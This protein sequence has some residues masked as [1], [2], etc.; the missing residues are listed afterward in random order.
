[1]VLEAMLC[2]LGYTPTMACNGREAL[3][4]IE[5]RSFDLVLTDMRMPDLDGAAMTQAI[6]R[7]LGD[8]APFVIAVTATAESEAAQTTDGFD[9][10]LGKPVTLGRLKEAIAASRPPTRLSQ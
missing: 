5:T 1:M 10:Y 6:R 4:T 8:A 3:Q 2:E 7:R 9:A